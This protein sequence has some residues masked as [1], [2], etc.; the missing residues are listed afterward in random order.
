MSN[1]KETVVEII[2]RKGKLVYKFE[3]AAEEANHNGDADREKNMYK[4][5]DKAEEYV[6]GAIDVLEAMGYEIKFDSNH[7]VEEIIGEGLN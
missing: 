6:A 4:C 1:W 7:Y 5:A 2:R 3:K